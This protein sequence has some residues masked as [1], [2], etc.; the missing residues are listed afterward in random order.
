[1]CCTVFVLKSG[2]MTG[3]LGVNTLGTAQSVALSH[4]SRVMGKPDFC[5]G[6]NKVADQLRSNCEADQRLCLR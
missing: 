4:M 2:L 5:L 3:F 1:M 6:E